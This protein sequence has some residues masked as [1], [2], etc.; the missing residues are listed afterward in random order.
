[1]LFYPSKNNNRLNGRPFAP[2]H[3]T[4]TAMVNP[5]YR[6]GLA[7]GTRYIIDSGAFQERDMR[8]RLQPWSA[9]DRQLRLEAQIEL[10]G[11]G[12][13]AEALITYD[14]LDGVDEA[15][16]E[17]GRIKRRGTEES[18]SPAVVETIRAARYYHTQAHRVRGAIAYACQGVTTAQYVA[19]AKSILPLLRP[20]R[21][22]L[23]LGGFCIVGQ[24]PSLKPMLYAALR[25]LLPLMERAG[26]GR[27]HIL[28]VTVADAVVECSRIARGS[29]VQ[30]STDS[31]GPERN[32][33]VY[34]RMF[35][36]AH[37]KGPRF[38]R[39]YDRSEKF[40]TY[41]PRDAAMESIRRYDRWCT[42]LQEQPY[43][44]AAD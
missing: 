32:A 22:W 28:G 4:G 11:C 1:M 24:V 34:G 20:G 14:M 30:L 5:H 8:A 29:P 25:E 40:I 38:A 19:C 23:S 39:T 36:P 37:P 41:H 35:E 21:D 7:P 31:S 17:E 10:T 15:L 27:A 44:N 18:A 13:P 2:E 9:L 6:V 12:A 33:A 43:A 26:V 42:A 3:I 16:T